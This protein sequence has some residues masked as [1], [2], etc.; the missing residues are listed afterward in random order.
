MPGDAQHLRHLDQ[1]L[2][3]LPS[4][5]F[6]DLATLIVV[7]TN[8][9]ALFESLQGLFTGVP[10]VKVIVDRRMPSRNPGRVSPRGKPLVERRPEE[11][12][13]VP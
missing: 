5:S 12:L 13:L 6:P 1:L 10:D 4:R 11:F 8:D 2:K 7:R 9:T 3:D